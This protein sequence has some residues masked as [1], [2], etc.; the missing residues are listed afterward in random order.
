MKKQRV[1]SIIL[2]LVM[3]FSMYPMNAFAATK[4][5]ISKTNLVFQKGKGSQSY[6]LKVYYGS[7]DVTNSCTWKSSNSTVAS[8]KKGKVAVAGPRGN[9]NITATY[10]NQKVTCRVL[11]AEVYTKTLTF[12]YGSDFSKSMADVQAKVRGLYGYGSNKP[13]IVDAEVLEWVKVKV[14]IVTYGPLAKAQYSY[15]YLPKKIKYT[16][17]K[18]DLQPITTCE[19]VGKAMTSA[20]NF[21]IAYTTTCSC[22][23]SSTTT[24][25]IPIAEATKMATAKSKITVY[26]Q[27]YNTNGVTLV[28]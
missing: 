24:W 11:I 18:H 14:P 8:V 6:Q 10:K 16:L 1:A 9:T 2:I 19:A 22:G 21:E 26:T 23:L 5:T 28:K 4:L 20:V 25:K 3:L 7:K 17:H 13:M 27:T 15:Q 12:T